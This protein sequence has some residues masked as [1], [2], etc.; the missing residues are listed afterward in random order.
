MFPY[1]ETKTFTKIRFLELTVYF[2]TR[3]ALNLKFEL[4]KLS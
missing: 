3:R 1:L 2:T 4:Q